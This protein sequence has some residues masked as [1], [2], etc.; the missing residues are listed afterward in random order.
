MHS[1]HARIALALVLVAA[2]AAFLQSGAWES[3]APDRFRETILALGPLG[4]VLF[5]AAFALLE[6]FHVPGLIFLLSAPMIWP[7]P[8]AFALCLAGATGAGL[9]ALV[10]A[11]LLARDWVQ[12]RLPARFRAWDDRLAQHGLRTVV[13]I[14]L[15]TFLWP[16]A[17]WV[18]GLSSVRVSSALVGTAVGLA[19]GILVCT[20]LGARLVAWW[21]LVPGELWLGLAGLILAGIWLRV[22]SRRGRDA[23]GAA[24][25]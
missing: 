14:R 1:S 23:R 16:A 6:P 9:V 10:I 20:W 11:R 2:A 15:L 12:A 22:R 13:L 19:P 4:P 21:D 8:A 17:H 18:I 7:L 3:L 5:V 25:A 24:P